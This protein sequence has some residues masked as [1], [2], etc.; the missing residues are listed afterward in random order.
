MAQG[1]PGGLLLPVGGWG[2]RLVG[3]GV[4]VVEPLEYLA[5]GARLHGLEF[6]AFGATD[7]DDPYA[8]SG[9]WPR[10]GGMSL[11]GVWSVS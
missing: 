3:L 4:V 6:G 5:D 1:R 10:N 2:G 8:E 7:V 11:V 9:S